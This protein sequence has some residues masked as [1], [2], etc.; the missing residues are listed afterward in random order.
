MLLCGPCEQ[1]MKIRL[2]QK[3]AFLLDLCPE[4]RMRVKQAFKMMKTG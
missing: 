4:C 3:K 1:I 2:K